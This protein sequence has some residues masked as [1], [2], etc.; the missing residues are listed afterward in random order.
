M[1]DYG[2]IILDLQELLYLIKIYCHT[3]KKY[4]I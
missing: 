1:I 4:E 2:K 3:G